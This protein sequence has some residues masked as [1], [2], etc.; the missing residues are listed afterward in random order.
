LAL[1]TLRAAHAKT[2]VSS[3]GI[4]HSDTAGSVVVDQLAVSTIT[5]SFLGNMARGVA[6]LT[7]PTAC[8][9]VASL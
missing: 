8:S 2:V 3:D 4:G 1:S 7:S 5:G 6:S 9:D